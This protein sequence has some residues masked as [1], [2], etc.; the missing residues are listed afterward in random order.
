M[1]PETDF[2]RHKRIL[3]IVLVVGVFLFGLKVWLYWVTKSNAILSDALESI[4]NIFAGAF[5]LY[6]LIL[7][8]KPSD[9]KHPYGHG[10]IE[11]LSASIEGA[12]IIAAG[13]VIIIKSIYNFY[14]G[15]LKNKPFIFKN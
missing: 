15:E 11:F 10:K 12:M 7:A 2:Q 3:S 5:A 13:L 8:N 4:V 14:E 1:I 9:K 6:S